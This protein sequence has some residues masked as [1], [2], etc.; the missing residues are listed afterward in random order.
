[1]TDKSFSRYSNQNELAGKEI[2]EI[3]PILLGGSATDLQNKTVLNRDQHV[4]AVN[5]WNSVVATLRGR[6]PG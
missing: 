5:Y 2:F 3:K 1:M 6:R 4:K